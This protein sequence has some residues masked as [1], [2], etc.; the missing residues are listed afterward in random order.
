MNLD[1]QLE[2]DNE[3]NSEET[4]DIQ[5]ALEMEIDEDDIH[6]YIVDENDNEIGFILID[7][8]GN[9]QEY[10]YVDL[11]EYDVVSEE[12]SDTTNSSDDDFDLGITREGVAEAT[13]DVNAI[14]K[15]GIELVAELKGAFDDISEEMNFLKKKR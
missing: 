3:Q 12:K 8:N 13:A 6:A 7:E 5:E 4:C 15:D 11:S 14:Y 2:I 10:Y 9:E 1:K